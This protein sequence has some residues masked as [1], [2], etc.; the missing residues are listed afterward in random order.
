MGN[1]ASTDNLKAR[2]END[3]ALAHLTDTPDTGTPDDDVL[4]EVINHAENELDSIIGFK[5]EVPVK[6][7]DH[8]SLANIMRSKT[9]DM[10]VLY[11]YQRHHSITEAVQ[12]G[13][14]RAIAW[15]DRVAG[16]ED[17]A[18]LPT[19]DTEP[20]TLNREPLI[21]HG[22]SDASLS[23]SRRIFTRSTTDSI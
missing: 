17:H 18:V 3:A 20:T 6:V 22:T 12:G 5:H 1:Y 21:T 9:L 7:A 23:T 19:T 16:S 11:L 2:F 4:N 15:A 14:D 8:A 13:F 10:A